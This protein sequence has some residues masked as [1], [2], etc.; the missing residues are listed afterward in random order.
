M[1]KIIIILYAAFFLVSCGGGS[2]TPPTPENSAPTA[3]E[4]NYPTNNLLCIDNVIEFNW[5]SSSDPDKDILSYEVQIAKNG[6]FSPIAHS[7]KV[8][9]TQRT[10]SLEKGIE[11]FWRVKAVDSK[12]ASSNF[13][14][15]NQFYTEGEGN[16]NHL[17]FSP[18]LVSPSIGAIESGA[19]VNLQW[20]ASDPDTDDTLSYDIYFGTASTPSTIHTAN[21]GVTNLE[22]NLTSSTTYFWKVIV[23]DDKGGQTNG[24]V[25]TFKTD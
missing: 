7:I 25:W 15:T 19:T 3:P 23:K 4:L 18:A 14:D 5:N 8:S 1:K 10:I 2:D 16:S 6:Q 11:Y 22:V 12:N 9:S 13:S 21:L 24:Q 17:P 20:S